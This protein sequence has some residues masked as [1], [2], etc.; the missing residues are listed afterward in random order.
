MVRTL[1]NVIK[2]VVSILVVIVLANWIEWNDA[3]LS[4]HVKEQMEKFQS[5]STYHD[6]HTW[7]GKV[8]DQAK[9][10]IKEKI[11]E[12]LSNSVEPKR[13]DHISSSQS[14]AMKAPLDSDQEKLRALIGSID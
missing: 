4:H 10:R 6:A 9:R 2:L 3:T 12:P 5:S 11:I 7:T 1:L 13:K 14:R 8:Y